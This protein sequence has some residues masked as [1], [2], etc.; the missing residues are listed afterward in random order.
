MSEHSSR[1]SIRLAGIIV[2]E[3]RARGATRCGIGFWNVLHVFRRLSMGEW[4]PAP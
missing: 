3:A 1:T 2:D 4:A